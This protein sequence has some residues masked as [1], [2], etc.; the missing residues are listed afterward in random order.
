LKPS[1]SVDAAASI[2]YKYCISFFWGS[3]W[4]YNGNLDASATIQLSAHINVGVEDCTYTLST[5][6]CDASVSNLQI[7]HGGSLGSILN[8]LT[9]IFK[10]KIADVFEQQICPLVEKQIMSSGTEAIQSFNKTIP[11]F[12]NVGIDYSL[13]DSVVTGG[14]YAASKLKGEFYSSLNPPSGCK[15]PT[16]S[17]P[18]PPPPTTSPLPPKPPTPSPRPP[19]PPPPPPTSIIRTI[20]RFGR[21][22]FGKKRSTGHRFIRKPSNPALCPG[23][24]PLTP[25]LASNCPYYIR[26]SEYSINTALNAIYESGI[27]QH[28]FCL[29]S[30]FSSALRFLLLLTGNQ[31]CNPS[32]ITNASDYFEQCDHIIFIKASS[33]PVVKLEGGKIIFEFDFSVDLLASSN[34]SACTI[35]GTARAVGNVSIITTPSGHKVVGEVHSFNISVHE[36]ELCP[37]LKVPFI[38]SAL[39]SQTG[40]PNIDLHSLFNILAESL[41][42]PQLNKVLAKGFPLPELKHVALNHPKIHLN[43]GYGTA[44]FDVAYAT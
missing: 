33:A 17:P 44:C 30:Q 38:L 22:L 24:I 35:T 12:K 42:R 1:I 36:N 5:S 28:F 6:Q 14:N 15:R 43:E 34:C 7:S 8:A 25:E 31:L 41:A 9:N 26:A 20:I 37:L 39:R 19:P 2:G 40:I 3:S 16:I 10:S 4:C 13:L 27:L 23:P 18:L 32:V 11:L 21:R 29:P